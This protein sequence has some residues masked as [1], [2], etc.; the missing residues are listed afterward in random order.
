[1]IFLLEKEKEAGH[2]IYRIPEI[3]NSIFLTLNT[4]PKKANKK[5]PSAVIVLLFF[6]GY[7]IIRGLWQLI[8]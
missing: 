2:Y 6:D 7:I 5:F 1:M 3:L 8:K 4:T